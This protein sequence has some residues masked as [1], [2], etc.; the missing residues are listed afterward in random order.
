[1]PEPRP[2]SARSPGARRDLGARA[3]QAG[4][5]DV[6]EEDRASEMPHPTARDARGTAGDRMNGSR[7]R[8]S[9]DEVHDDVEKHGRRQRWHGRDS[10]NDACGEAELCR[11]LDRWAH[12]GEIVDEPQQDVWHRHEDPDLE[13]R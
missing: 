12:V 13:R 9:E 2:A 11:A 6:C 5:Q 7:R 4:D 8:S 1:M 10:G 3:G